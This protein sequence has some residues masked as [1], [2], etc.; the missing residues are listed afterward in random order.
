MNT[1]VY[2]LPNLLCAE[3]TAIGSNCLVNTGTWRDDDEY[4]YTY[5]LL[6]PKDVP[7]FLGCRLIR[8]DIIHGFMVLGATSQPLALEKLASREELIIWLDRTLIYTLVPGKPAVG[9]VRVRLPNNVATFVGL[10]LHI[11]K[12]GFPGHWLSEYFHAILH[13]NLITEISPYPGFVRSLLISTL[14]RQLIVL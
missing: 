5:T 9:A 4:C 12:V 2:S 11:H 7:R 8:R 13:N 1:A 3:D 6:L 10:L 14:D